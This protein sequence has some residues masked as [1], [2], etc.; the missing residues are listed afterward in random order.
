MQSAFEILSAPQFKLEVKRASPR[1]VVMKD[2]YAIYA[3]EKQRV[4]RKKYNWRKYIL[5]L[6][7]NKIKHSSS[8][9]EKFQKTKNYTKELP[10]ETI[11]IFLARYKV[12]RLYN[13]LSEAKDI[14]NRG[15]SASAFIVSSRF[16]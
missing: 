13:I 14:N 16:V 1:D 10:I 15:G 11:A 9:V 6:K 8:A 4:L 12:D 2:I 5:W 7:E 3:S